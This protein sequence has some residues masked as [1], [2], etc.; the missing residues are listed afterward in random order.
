MKLVKGCGSYALE[1]KFFLLTLACD[2]EHTDLDHKTG[3]PQ[4]FK[5]PIP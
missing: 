5:N 3:F 2:L 4:K 1:E